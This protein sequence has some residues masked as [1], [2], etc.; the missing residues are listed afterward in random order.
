MK[1]L[2]SLIFL[3]L[4]PGS[5]VMCWNG[6]LLISNNHGLLIPILI[7]AGIGLF[8]YYLI[9]KRL[10][11][12]S[13][14]EHELTHALVA[15]CFFRR[16][17]GFRVTSKQGGLMSHKGRFGGQLGDTMI[18]LAPY[19]LPTLTMITVIIRLF[20]HSRYLIIADGVI[21]FTL[22]YHI[23]SNFKELQNN[24]TGRAF[25][26]I[27]GEMM[28]TDIKQSGYILSFVTIIALSLFFYGLVF[29]LMAYK[30]QGFL[31]ASSLSFHSSW[32]ILCQLYEKIRDLKF[33]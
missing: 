24:W 18:T 6:L 19:F 28:V 8:T 4:I 17:T 1:L 13:T 30:G 33:F 31:M 29:Y 20:L 5:A 3:F 16:V 23:L 21:G 12:L 27:S 22:I 15:L 10:T 14:F 9:V 32:G 25:H 2:L 7:G 11:W 26:N